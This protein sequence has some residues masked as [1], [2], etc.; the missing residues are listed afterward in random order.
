MNLLK[1]LFAGGTNNLTADD[2]KDRIDNKDGLYILD[3]REKHE[4]QGGHIN[5]AKHI[6]LGN[7]KN[8]MNELPK[9]KEIL[10]VC[11][12]GARSGSAVRH[13]NGAGF[14]AINLR[15]G[16]MSWQHAGYPIKKGK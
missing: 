13:L 3:V 4:Y 14:T 5:G 1:S 6:P 16:M 11:R 7:L 8:R 2:V 15:G 9:D 10:C 12:S